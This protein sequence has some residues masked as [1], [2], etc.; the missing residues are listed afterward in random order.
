MKLS[1]YL[2]KIPDDAYTNFDWL[3]I[4]QSRVLEADWLMLGNGEKATLHISMPCEGEN[5]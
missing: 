5:A 1:S 3:V 4:Y 2:L